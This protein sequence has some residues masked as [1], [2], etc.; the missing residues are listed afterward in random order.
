MVGNSIHGFKLGLCGARDGH[1][2]VVFI[3]VDASESDR[4]GWNHGKCRSVSS[5]YRWGSGNF[6]SR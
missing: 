5:F 3:S 6:G 2:V 4:G 1:L